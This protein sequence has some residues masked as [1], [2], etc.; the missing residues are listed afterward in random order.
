MPILRFE[1]FFAA[2]RMTNSISNAILNNL[3]LRRSQARCDS[4]D[5]IQHSFLNESTFQS[6]ARRRGLLS[7]PARGVVEHET[8]W[9]RHPFSP[10]VRSLC[11]QASQGIMVARR[12]SASIKDSRQTARSESQAFK[13]G[14]GMIRAEGFGIGKESHRPFRAVTF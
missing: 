1:R 10:H 12:S 6:S 4:S 3:F 14:A 5:S 7:V 11:D 8:D 2:L 13:P 9:K